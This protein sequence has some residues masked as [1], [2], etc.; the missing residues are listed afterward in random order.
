M[1]MSRDDHDRLHRPKRAIT[2]HGPNIRILREAAQVP[3]A[4]LAQR[5]SMTKS[6]LCERE[7]GK[8]FVSDADFLRAKMALLEIRSERDAAFEQAWKNI[9]GD[10]A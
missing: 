5:L 4:M 2:Q 6:K 9:T 8:L 7:T 1:A 10:A 3:Q